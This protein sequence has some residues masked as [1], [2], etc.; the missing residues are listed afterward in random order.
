MSLRLNYLRCW[1]LGWLE[2]PAPW[3]TVCT[4]SWSEERGEAVRRA[5]GTSRVHLETTYLLQLL[6]ARDVHRYLAS[7]TFHPR[8]RLLLQKTTDLPRGAGRAGS[9]K[10][11]FSVCLSF[12]LV[13]RVE[14]NLRAE[15]KENS[16]ETWRRNTALQRNRSLRKHWPRTR[17]ARRTERSPATQ[18]SNSSAWNRPRPVPSL[19]SFN[20]R[21]GRQR[22]QKPSLDLLVVTR[23]EDVDPLMVLWLHD[24]RPPPLHNC[25]LTLK[26]VCFFPQEANQFF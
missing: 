23:S 24:R 6:H 13:I 2:K 21:R 12:Y 17:C 19:W 26:K 4:W 7:G 20:W 5:A 1:P 15:L 11:I 10:D 9:N 14:Q 22:E 8:H 18:N 3:T 25:L 16:P